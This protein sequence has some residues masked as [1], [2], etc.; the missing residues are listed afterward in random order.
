MSA[1][2]RARLVGITE[3]AERLEVSKGTVHKWRHR[4]LL[5]PAD[6]HLAG[7]PVWEWATI[8]AWARD[9][10]RLPDHTHFTGQPIF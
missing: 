9:T 5:P 10:H 3:I 4:N 2:S 8:E 6:Y 7:G 1:D